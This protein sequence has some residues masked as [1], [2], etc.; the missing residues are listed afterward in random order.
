M[1]LMHVDKLL[2]FS[3]IM[4]KHVIYSYFLWLTLSKTQYDHVVLSQFFLIEFM[5]KEIENCINCAWV[6]IPKSFGYIFMAYGRMTL[7]T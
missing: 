4:I 2:I 5:H 3:K 7:G 6:T 1:H